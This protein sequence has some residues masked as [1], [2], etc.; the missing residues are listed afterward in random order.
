MDAQATAVTDDAAPYEAIVRLAERELELAGEGRYDEIAQLARE[1]AQLLAALP[2]APPSIA[3]E[4]LERALEVQRRVTVELLHRHEEV[5]LG[6]RRIELS[7]RTAREYG[8]PIGAPRGNRLDAEGCVGPTGTR[9]PGGSV[10]D[11]A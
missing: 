6:L 10:G 11:P 7:R 1:R 5:L 8:D 2:A 3:R 4:A 9:A